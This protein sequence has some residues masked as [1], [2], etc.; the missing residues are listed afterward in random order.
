M[1]NS[2]FPIALIVV[3]AG[4]LVNEL[5]ILPQANWIVILGLITAGVMV[6]AFDGVNSSSIVKAP[7]LIAAGIA[8]LVHQQGQ[9]SWSILIP[10]L[11]ILAGLLL[12]IGRSGH[13]PPRSE[14]SWRHGCRPDDSVE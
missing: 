7:L 11:L 5:N 12:L 10:A 8:T 14:K 9:V 4:W 6:L 1:R 2:F 3:G 13:L